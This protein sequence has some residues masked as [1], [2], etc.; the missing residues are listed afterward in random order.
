MA[1]RIIIGCDGTWSKFDD[2]A[3][4]NLRRFIQLLKP[5]AS[6]GTTQLI[7]Y[8]EGIGS[9][10]FDKLPGGAFGAGIDDKIQAVYRFLCLNYTA[11]DEL[12][13]FGYSRGA[14]T[15]RSLGGLIDCVGLLSPEQTGQLEAAYEI[16]R[17]QN[18]DKRK[19]AAAAFRAEYQTQRIPITLL[20]CWDTVGAL[21]IP[22]LIPN[23]P[24]DYWANK[25]YRF[26]NTRLSPLIQHAL[27]VAALDEQQKVFSLTPMN[28]P[29]GSPTRLKQIWFPGEHSTVGSAYG[30]PLGDLTLAWMVQSI[31]EF[32]L[33]LEFDADKVNAL[34]PDPLGGTVRDLFEERRRWNWSFFTILGLKVREI[35]AEP[36][37]ANRQQYF[38]PG[39][40][41]R[42]CQQAEYRSK[43][44]VDRGWASVFDAA[45]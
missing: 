31:G 1:K 8:Q 20:G 17:I 19:A 16:Y 38:H 42:W 32:G 34:R 24:I 13:L 5:T 10:W 11:G 39:V 2:Q 26:H 7:Q 44:L 23:L 41:Q 40:S 36:N 22:D 29:E 27:H 25:P 43:C 18:D 12:Y 3:P 14:Y 45:C 28:L 30:G 6:D 15:V 37:E 4:T 9:R 21:G 35:E 33:G